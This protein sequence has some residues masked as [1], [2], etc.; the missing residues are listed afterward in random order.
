MLTVDTI[1]WFCLI[2]PTLQ[3]ETVQ[4]HYL[5]MISSLWRLGTSRLSRASSSFRLNG[6]WTC[7]GH[8]TVRSMINCHSISEWWLAQQSSDEQ[9][10][11]CGQQ[12][13][14]QDVSIQGFNPPLCWIWW[15]NDQPL[16]QYCCNCWS[17]T[18][19]NQNGSTNTS[20][21]T[22]HIQWPSLLLVISVI[23][24]D[25]LSSPFLL[26][27]HHET[28]GVTCHGPGLHPNSFTHRSLGRNRRPDRAFRKGE[29]HGLRELQGTENVGKR[30][31][32]KTGWWWLWS[33]ISHG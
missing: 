16:L 5:G 25:H 28:L 18:I 13:G 23:S 17:L 3:H 26:A 33:M 24:V 31:A 10:S 27:N 21:I 32:K 7:C 19:K 22:S 8:H 2:V 1:C 4:G 12:C 6:C 9:S 30:C 11:R 15:L 20:F 14:F 29:P